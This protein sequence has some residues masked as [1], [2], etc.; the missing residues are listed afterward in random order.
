MEEGFLKQ[1][2]KVHWL[3]VGDGNNLYFHK[4]VQIRLPRY[5][6]QEVKGPMGEIYPAKDDV[7][8]EA[9]RFL[10]EL[11]MFI[12]TGFTRLSTESLK[13]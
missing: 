5:A 3:G 9:V 12:P 4:S 7:K 8:N 11:F 2:S 10:E 1:K 6:I 13:D